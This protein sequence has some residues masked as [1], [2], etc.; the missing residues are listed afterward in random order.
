MLLQKHFKLVPNQDNNLEELINELALSKKNINEIRK[1]GTKLKRHNDDIHKGYDNN[2][3]DKEN[4]NNLSIN[5]DN[6]ICEND[7]NL[8]YK[9]DNITYKKNN[10]NIINNNFQVRTKNGSISN[11]LLNKKRREEK[12]K[13]QTNIS[14]KQDNVYNHENCND[15]SMN[16]IEYSK[17]P[18][19]KNT[20]EYNLLCSSNVLNLSN[21]KDNS[22]FQRIFKSI[23][24]EKMK[25][26][27]E[28]IKNKKEQNEHIKNE[29]IKNEHIRNEHIRNEHIKN[30]HIKNENINNE[31][32]K[33][34]NIKN[35]KIKNENIKNKKIKNEKT[36]YERSHNKSSDN[37]SDNII[38]LEELSKDEKKKKNEIL[39]A[40]RKCSYNNTFR[41][42]SP[43]VRTSEYTDNISFNTNNENKNN[44]FMK[45][46][47]TN[48][49][50]DVKRKRYI[51]YNDMNKKET[52]N[53]KYVDNNIKPLYHIWN[54][55]NYTTD[56]DKKK[57]KKKG[58]Q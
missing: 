43:L 41:S 9:E 52:K 32:I 23:E 22:L 29:Y 37:I 57:K 1:Y 56:C 30:E 44:K 40:K 38:Q 14:K 42:F 21:F 18:I 19:D 26:K 13:E 12:M 3:E 49:N 35:E 6:I 53:I 45:H 7:N 20:S 25:S 58:R 5:K 47:V 51:Y 27:Y 46:N 48:Y 10:K 31:K 50:E 4:Y 36:I 15:K 17:Y 55:K 8:I 39:K 34:E 28:K 16:K 54:K 11:L 24:E 33:N 2:I